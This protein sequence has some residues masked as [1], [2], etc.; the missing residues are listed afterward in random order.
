MPYHT[1]IHDIPYLYSYLVGISG[2]KSYLFFYLRPSRYHSSCP[3]LTAATVVLMVYSS[4][5]L[6]TGKLVGDIIKYLLSVA[7][8]TLMRLDTN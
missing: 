1:Y 3:F 8:A 6:A 5:L 4:L 7:L 2:L